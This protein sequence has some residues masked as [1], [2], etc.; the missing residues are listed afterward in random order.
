MSMKLL[1]DLI[2]IR[3]TVSFLTSGLAESVFD[4]GQTE[5]LQNCILTVPLSLPF[6]RP[7]LTVVLM[8]MLCMY[9]QLICA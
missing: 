5:E 6:V 3:G 1:V 4:L 7:C 8:K 9:T 2:C